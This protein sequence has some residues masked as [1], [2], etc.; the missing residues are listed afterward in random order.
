MAA[1]QVVAGRVDLDNKRW[2]ATS[3]PRGCSLPDSPF[4]KDV[5]LDLA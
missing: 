5:Y 2:S 4:E 1:Y 3:S